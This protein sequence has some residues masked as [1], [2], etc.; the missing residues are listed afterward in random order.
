MQ[1]QRSKRS[2]RFD[3]TGYGKALT[4]RSGTAAMREL[5]D[6]IGLT[7]AFSTAWRRVH[8]LADDE[9]AL[10]CLDDARRVSRAAAWQAGAA[11]AA[12]ADPSGG[13]CAS[14]STRPWS[15]RIRTPAPGRRHLQGGLGVSSAAGLLGPR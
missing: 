1:V 6:R 11:P 14:T 13:R 5:A 9:Q 7:D 12:V 10:A 4:G 8:N 15:R 3:V 2:P